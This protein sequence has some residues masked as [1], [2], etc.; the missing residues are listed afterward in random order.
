MTGLS[1]ATMAQA[2][3][4]IVFDLDD[5]LY[6]ERDYVFSGFKAV[7]E[8]AQSAF[9]VDADRAFRHLT[10]LF[11]AG[12]RGNTFDRWFS[13]FGL[14]RSKVSEAVRVYRSHIPTLRLFPGAL[15]ILR[16]LHQHYRLGLL[17]DGY[18]ATQQAKFRAL[19]LNGEFDA[20]VYSDELGRDY[21]KPSEKPFI[22]IARLLDLP[23]SQLVYVADNPA[24]DFVAPKKLRMGTIRVTS[25][26]GE[27]ARLTPTAAEYAPDLTLS[28]LDDF[29]ELFAPGDKCLK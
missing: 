1:L 12:M 25:C 28:S 6:P 10:S 7:G 2:W 16:S 27:Y 18:L 21:W 26:G 13:D 4:G 8:W 5:T 11:E 29:K 20:V 15:E 9:S 17:T 22:T 24:K 14:P 19:D 23:P 3:R